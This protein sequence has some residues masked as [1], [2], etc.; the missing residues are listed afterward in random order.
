M[1]KRKQLKLNQPKVKAEKP[2]E[3]SEEDSMEDIESEDMDD[4]QHVKGSAS[5]Y[6]INN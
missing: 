6:E 3:D 2:S 4:H 1:N 5:L